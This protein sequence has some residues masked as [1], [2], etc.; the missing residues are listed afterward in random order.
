MWAGDLGRLMGEGLERVRVTVIRCTSLY[1]NLSKNK[2]NTLIFFLKK[3]SRMEIFTY[4]LKQV[5]KGMLPGNVI[6]PLCFKKKN[7]PKHVSLKSFLV[8]GFWVFLSKILHSP[9]WPQTPSIVEND[10]E[11]VRMTFLQPHWVY[12]KTWTQGSVWVRQTTSNWDIFPAHLYFKIWFVLI[13]Y[14]ARTNWWGFFY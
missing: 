12:A 4:L 6:N 8:F 14:P 11:L 2:F 10:L 1:R 7:T 9:S 3:E 5:S 13:G